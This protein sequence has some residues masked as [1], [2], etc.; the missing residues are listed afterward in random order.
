MS[1]ERNVSEPPE[2]LTD[3]PE[4]FI[5]PSE[6][7]TRPIKPST[8]S[9]NKYHLKLGCCTSTSKSSRQQL[10]SVSKHNFTI[11]C[12]FALPHF[13]CFLI[14][15]Q[16]VCTALINMSIYSTYTRRRVA[17]WTRNIHNIH[18]APPRPAPF[19]RSTTEPTGPTDQRHPKGICSSLLGLPL[20]QSVNIRLFALGFVVATSQQ[21]QRQR[22]RNFV[23]QSTVKWLTR[24][25]GKTLNSG[26]GPTA[27]NE[28]LNVY[29]R[30]LFELICLKTGI[31][32]MLK[33]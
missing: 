19:V 31:E 6:Q 10:G 29:A 15:F 13:P 11:L 22:R 30:M 1:A 9:P 32:L 26:E 20:P 2:N 12:L 27:R 23:D 25:L 18:P 5:W 16:S 21:Q 3:D 24:A 7:T 8:V 33:L 4:Q 28:F 17:T 14:T